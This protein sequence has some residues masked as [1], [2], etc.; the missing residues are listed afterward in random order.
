MRPILIIAALTNAALLAA[1]AAHAE[2]R[3]GPPP[4]RAPQVIPTAVLSWPGKQASPSPDAVPRPAPTARS[5][6]PTS[7]YT[8]PPPAY[9]PRPSPD[10]SAA[11]ATTASVQPMVAP[12]EGEPPRFY[13]VAREYGVRPDPI[14]LS[15]QFLADS[16]ATDLAEPPPL[17]PPHL[18]SAQTA[19]M[20]TA[21]AANQ[22]R[23][24]LEAAQSASAASDASALN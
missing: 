4:E 7:I 16:G 8:P 9:A 6:L 18:N 13:S 19:N 5:N 2:D 17:P 20:S 22:T 3:Y 21:A 1:G 10:A 24:A 15:P 23:A 11:S 14:A 12:G